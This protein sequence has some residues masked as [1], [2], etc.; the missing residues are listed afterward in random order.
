MQNR[1]GA[2]GIVASARAG[3][4]QDKIKRGAENQGTAADGAGS[5]SIDS[6]GGVSRAPVGTFTISVR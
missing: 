4:L 3:F 2:P 1:G 5:A 6:D